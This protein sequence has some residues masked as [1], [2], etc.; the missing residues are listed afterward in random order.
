MVMDKPDEGQ[1]IPS[2]SEPSGTGVRKILCRLAG[3]E[4]LPNNYQT[5][6]LQQLAEMAE[7]RHMPE[8][9]RLNAQIDTL[10]EVRDSIQG[11]IDRKVRRRQEEL[12]WHAG[13]TEFERLKR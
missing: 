13:I 12:K 9:D 3:I 1:P 2:R 8:I 7:K 4:F 11:R 6:T 10:L 5:H